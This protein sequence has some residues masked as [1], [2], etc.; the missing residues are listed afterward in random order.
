M[1]KFVKWTLIVLVV[2]IIAV[3]LG[4]HFFLD[5]MIKRGVETVGPR[6]TKVTVKLDSAS[7]SLLSGSGKIKGLVIGNP[8]GFKSP[9]AMTLGSSSLSLVPQSIFADKVIIKSI[10]VEAPEIT[11]ES[12]L[13]SINLKKL[14]SNIQETA[15][16]PA[17]KK[18]NADPASSKPAKKLQVDE[19]IISNGKVHVSV[20]TPLGGQSATVK[21]PEIRLKDL[22][23][24]P[25]GI[26]P[27][28]LA[29]KVLSVIIEYAEKEGGKIVTDIANGAQFQAGEVINKQLG[30]NTVEKATKGLNDLLNR[31]K[32]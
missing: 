6:V 28:E 26:T 7:L 2:L 9:S 32:K 23:T 11:M 31:P 8:A 22:G 25:E 21:L 16:S 20:N 24:G 27:A 12:E 14:L 10:N 17:D 29:R 3:V 30:T 13:T 18:A 19:F 15:G 1:K 4:V 5:G